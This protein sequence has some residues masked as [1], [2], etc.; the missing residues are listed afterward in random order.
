MKKTLLLFFVLLLVIM[1]DINKASPSDGGL[2]GNG[3]TV[4]EPLMGI[5]FTYPRDWNYLNASNSIAVNAPDEVSFL[6]I[7]VSEDKRFADISELK[8]F[9]ESEFPDYMWSSHKLGKREGFLGKQ[10]GVISPSRQNT[11]EAYFDEERG[12]ALLLSFRSTEE[13]LKDV[14]EIKATLKWK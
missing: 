1:P 12:R 6:T 14:F 10:E 9:L 4:E 11:I 13:T 8:I 7:Q 3:R 5:A 2:I